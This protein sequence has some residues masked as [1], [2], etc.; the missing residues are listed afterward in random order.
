[1]GVKF[2]IRGIVQGVG[3][4][5][6]VYRVATRL[7][8]KG[9]V[10]NRGEGVEIWVEGLR[11][12]EFWEEV[13]KNLPP[14]AR[15]EGVERESVPD[16]GFPDFRIWDSQPGESGA[17]IPPDTAICPDCRRELLDSTNRRYLYPFINC[18]NCGPRW[19]ILYNL[20]YDRSQTSMAPFEMCPRCRK[21][22]TDPSDRRYHAQP[23]SCW[24]CGPR[25]TLWREGKKVEG[26]PIKG[27]VEALERGEIV[28]VKGVGGFHLLAD[29][30]NP[31]AVKHLRQIKNRPKKPFAVMF[32]SLQEAEKWVKL[33][34][35]AR[36]ILTSPQAPIAL[37]PKRPDRELP[38]VAPEIGKLGIF[39]PYSP[40]H[41]L[42]L[43][44]LNR[45]VV[46][47]SCNISDTPLAL[48]REE[49][50]KLG[51]TST[52]LDYNREIV[53]GADDSVVE[54]G[55][56]KPLFFRLGRGY[57][58][59]SRRVNWEIPEGAIATGGNQKNTIALQVGDEVVISPHIGDLS[60][61]EGVAY[62]EKN[63]HRLITIYKTTPK[64]VVVDRHPH[65]LSRRWGV[66]WANRT[67]GEIWE[68]QHHYAHLMAVVGELEL[69]N[70]PYLGIAFDGT[71]YG[72]DG[73]IWGG[74]FFIF[75]HTGYRRVG[76][77]E[78]F[79]LIGGE[80]GIKDPLRIALGLLNQLGLEP[81]TP[82][83]WRT[84]LELVKKIASAPFPWS[85][86]M[87]RLFDIVGVLGGIIDRNWY[88]GY[89]G[90]LMEKYYTPPRGS[91]TPASPFGIP[92]QPPPSFHSSASSD[93]LAPSFTG[94]I[95]N[96]KDTLRQV[97]KDFA[98]RRK[99]FSLPP[100][101][102]EW[103]REP[104][105]SGKS[106]ERKKI[107]PSG[108]TFHPSPPV[109]H[110]SPWGDGFFSQNFDLS[111]LPGWQRGANRLGE[112]K[113]SSEEGLEFQIKLTPLL[114]KVL[115]NRG[116]PSVVSTLFIDWI[117]EV[118][119]TI[120]FGYQLP[121]VIAGGVFQNRVLLEQLKTH[122]SPLPLHFSHQLPPN[123]GALSFGQ[124]V[125][126]GK[127]RGN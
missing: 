61:R 11:V 105:F 109:S 9:Y 22:Y 76:R 60:T 62:L 103:K 77:L 35:S 32:P 123:D 122:L 102:I 51:F 48:T 58:P 125:A 110:Q 82:P 1:M 40:I 80:K 114:K 25:L 88:E 23:I 91:S 17:M 66:E 69:P 113:R 2:L 81:L 36:Q 84:Q 90:L 72:D 39:L 107:L 7:G 12:G 54:M 65:Y 38:G 71:G 26:D 78:P 6:S 31:E 3:F 52:I 49:V 55:G 10:F 13:E 106:E 87:G 83:K 44:E 112:W 4:R 92:D 21:E 100:V 111:T 27:V 47:T 30:H 99:S 127:G 56:N 74:E 46:A 20:P 117:V 75:D 126:V 45:G 42:I 97:E 96:Q 93:L 79:K 19:S 121:V 50:E 120:A 43:K 70:R 119:K 63:F 37:L 98:Q 115:E 94:G 57:S 68:V 29:A 34:P 18:T 67:G 108:K 16:R 53:N 5:P 101:E 59:V 15:V 86:S 85:S 104:I 118:I 8:L 124:I 95:S 28:A 64:I 33:T 89:S 116:N 24:E 14:L 73:T 41:L